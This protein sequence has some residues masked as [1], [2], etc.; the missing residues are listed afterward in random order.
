M[1]ERGLG[2]GY[3]YVIPWILINLQGTGYIGRERER[4]Y[5]LGKLSI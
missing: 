2:E 1:L 3:N 5:F 4:T